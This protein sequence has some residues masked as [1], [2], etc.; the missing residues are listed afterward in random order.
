MY[1]QLLLMKLYVIFTGNYLFLQKLLHFMN[2]NY[3]SARLE[4]VRL[5]N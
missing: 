1:L 3:S 4:F 2:V 5:C